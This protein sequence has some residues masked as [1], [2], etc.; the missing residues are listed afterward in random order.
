ML[1]A[2]VIFIGG[3]SVTGCAIARPNPTH[4]GAA[5]VLRDSHARVAVPR[6]GN[7][8]FYPPT[9]IPV[10][11]VVPGVTPHARSTV[12]DP[13]NGVYYPPALGKPVSPSRREHPRVER[14]RRTPHVRAVPDAGNG[15]YYPPTIPAPIAHR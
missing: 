7:G 12:P 9:P 8:V 6:S 15:V 14:G 11:P 5:K 4:R 3:V 13:G 1:V 2:A 10:T